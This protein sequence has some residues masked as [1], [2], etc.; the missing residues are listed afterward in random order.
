MQLL[1]LPAVLNDIIATPKGHIGVLTLN[2]PE[3]LHALTDEMIQL[4]QQALDQWR[5]DDSI[6][7]VLLL[8]DGHKAFCAG[9]DVRSV[10]ENAQLSRGEYCEY[11]E[12][13]FEAEYRLDYAIHHYPKPIVVWGEGI[14]LGGGLGLLAGASHRVVTPSS[15]LA[16]PEIGIGLF[17]D[18]GA[19]YFLNNMPGRSGY[20]LALSGSVFAASDAI[21]GGLADYCVGDESRAQFIEQLY[22]A[23]WVDVAK[24]DSAEKNSL[25]L[26][27]ILSTMAV[28]AGS[29]WL[30][31]DQLEI[32]QLC[33]GEDELTI[34]EQLL[35]YNGSSE[36]LLTAVAGLRRGS[37]LS[38]RI[39]TRQLLASRGKSLLDIFSSELI[40]ATNLASHAEFQEGVRALLV[41]KDKNPQWQHQSVVAVSED[42]LSAVFTP[43]WNCS[44]LEDLTR[45]DD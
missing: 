10:R 45:H 8:G 11:S 14:V 15:R 19:S 29:S 1:P 18:V 22:Q 26:S 23:S 33:D 16:M 42:E 6:V 31:A 21:Y 27:D 4:L 36:T 5:S 30:A 17:P 39:I 28:S 37:P 44:P 13:F 20:L 41:D 34:I 24:D 7:A 35:S 43:H 38:A 32:D 2:N 3:R 40:L 9:G 12:H 25:I